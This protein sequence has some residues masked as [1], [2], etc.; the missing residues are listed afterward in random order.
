[1]RPLVAAFAVVALAACDA[2]TPP[3]A[4][5][6][7][8]ASDAAMTDA[9]VCGARDEGDVAL[10]TTPRPAARVCSG[11]EVDGYFTAC[12]DPATLPIRCQQ[13]VAAHGDCARCLAPATG[14]DPSGPLWTVRGELALNVGGCIALRMGDLRPDGCGAREQA[15]IDCAAQR[16]DGCDDAA[17][18]AARV[19][20][21]ECAALETRRCPELAGAA[22]CALDGTF[23]A[24][25]HRVASVF[26]VGE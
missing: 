15:A 22:V 21:A 26:C 7:R 17:A 10:P 8:D 5:A 24:R 25:F 23:A 1:M 2:T 13:F 11:D 3:E 14:D 20:A 16:C 18:C 4:P 9:A 19:R 6:P 12:L